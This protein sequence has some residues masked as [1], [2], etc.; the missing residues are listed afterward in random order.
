MLGAVGR[1][2]RVQLVRASSTRP[3]PPR[4]RLVGVHRRARSPTMESNEVRPGGRA[5]SP[6]GSAGAG[7]PVRARSSRPSS[8]RSSCAPCYARLSPQA[9]GRALQLHPRD[10]RACAGRCS[11]PPSLINETTLSTT[12]DAGARVRRARRLLR[13]PQLSG[14]TTGQVE[15]RQKRSDEAPFPDALDLHRRLV[16][17]RGSASTPPSAAWPTS[18]SSPL[19]SSPR[20]SGS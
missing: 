3:A 8:S 13:C 6:S 12:A 4:D 14:L 7:R 11:P 1:H 5:S 15:A 18:S 20:S 19:P 16:S 9:R 17:R 10:A 2:R